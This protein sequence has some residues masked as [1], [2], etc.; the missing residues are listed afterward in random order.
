[1]PSNHWTDTVAT[2]VYLLNRMPSKILQ[3]RTPL[4]VLSTYVSVPS[5][6]QIPICIFG[7]VAYVHLHKNQQTKLDPCAIKCL[8]LG[9]GVQQKGYRCYN[10]QTRRVYVTMDVTFVESEL[11]YPTNSTLQRK[12]LSEVNN[13]LIFNWPTSKDIEDSAAIEDDENSK[14][15]KDSATI[16]KETEVNAAIDTTRK[17]RRI[18]GNN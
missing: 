18:Q 16:E 1:M 11:F 15:S 17:S 12:L 2:A 9:Y 13:W 4:Q 7:R 8:F 3:F 14:A 10:P 5:I 6:L